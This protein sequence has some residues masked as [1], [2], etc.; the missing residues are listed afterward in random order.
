MHREKDELDVGSLYSDSSGRIQPIQERHRYVRHNHVGPE[1]QGFRH[2]SAAVR[3][4]SNNPKSLFQIAPQC[5]SEHGVVIRNQEPGIIPASRHTFH[6]H[7]SAQ[8]SW[9]FQLN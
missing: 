4:H 3:Y 8:L 2:Q 9:H 1:S 7:A 5:F 6:G